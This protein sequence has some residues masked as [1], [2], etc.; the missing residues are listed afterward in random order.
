[1]LIN[2]QVQSSSISIRKKEENMSY[3]N[4]EIY[5]ISIGDYCDLHKIS[6]DE[7]IDSVSID[8]DILTA[9]LKE[10]Q[11]IM[12]PLSDAVYNLREKKYSHRDRLNEWARTNGE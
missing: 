12:N 2:N 6:I 4:D 1:V 10:I 5:G 11:D 3:N 7:L 9:R 8:I